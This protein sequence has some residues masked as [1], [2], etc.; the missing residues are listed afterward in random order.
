MADVATIKY[1]YPA[2]WGG[3]D[4]GPQGPG[5]RIVRVRLLFTASGTTGESGVVKFQPAQWRL[6]APAGTCELA[7]RVGILEA[8]YDIA[9]IDYV[10]LSWR[11]NPTEPALVLPTGNGKV[12]FRSDGGLWDNTDAVN[13]ND[14]ALLL[15]SAGVAANGSY[16]IDLTLQLSE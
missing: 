10:Q 15:T 7:K 11:R 3:N 6:Q 8:V 1:L 12:C 16:S 9:K 14:G 2:N 13:D 4:P 5:N